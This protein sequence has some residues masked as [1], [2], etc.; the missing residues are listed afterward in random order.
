MMQARSA[1]LQRQDPKSGDGSNRRLLSAWSLAGTT[2]QRAQRA[3]THIAGGLVGQ[4]I[5]TSSPGKHLPT[6]SSVQP[7]K[8]DAVDGSEHMPGESV[9][10]D[11]M[12]ID[13]AEASVMHPHTDPQ[14]GTDSVVGRVD[15]HGGRV[16]VIGGIKRAGSRSATCIKMN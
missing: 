7:G 4:L 15:A 8:S 9:G 2:L 6:H 12:S 1:I 5:A 14:A 13:E 16:I 10:R 11:P 3:P